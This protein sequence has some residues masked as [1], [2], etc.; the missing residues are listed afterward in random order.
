M[1]YYTQVSTFAL[2]IRGSLV[3]LLCKNSMKASNIATLLGR[4][5]IRVSLLR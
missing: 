5:I 4:L 1:I 3:Y 2:P